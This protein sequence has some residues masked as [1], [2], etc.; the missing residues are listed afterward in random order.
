M[1]NCKEL[2]KRNAAIYIRFVDVERE[3]LFWLVFLIIQK[4]KVE[5]NEKTL[6]RNITAVL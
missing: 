6:R 5:H 1:H 4:Q 2:D 3:R